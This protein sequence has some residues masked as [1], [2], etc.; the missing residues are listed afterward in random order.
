MSIVDEL[1]AKRAARREAEKGQQEVQAAKDLAAIV[2]LEET[3]GSLRYITPPEYRSGVVTVAAFR[4]ATRSEY[5]RLCDMISR[6]RFSEKNT[7][8]LTRKAQDMFGEACLVYPPPGADREALFDAFPGTL[9][10][11]ALA[12][13]KLAVLA[14]EDEGKD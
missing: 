7:G 9:I 11:V 2:A 10:S 5:K 4:P 8:D 3:M 1:V 6:A 13:E 14:S 12:A